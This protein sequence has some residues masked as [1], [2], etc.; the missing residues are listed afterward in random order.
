MYMYTTQH[1]QAIYMYTYTLV[2]G[3]ASADQQVVGVGAQHS[4]FS[5]PLFFLLF[6][7]ALWD[8]V[9]QF[10]T[11]HESRLPHWPAG[12]FRTHPLQTVHHHLQTEG[13]TEAGSPHCRLERWRLKTET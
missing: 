3:L 7:P 10:W 6:P 11:P 1:V 12:R 9:P 4:I 2:H 5:L 13:Q 8:G